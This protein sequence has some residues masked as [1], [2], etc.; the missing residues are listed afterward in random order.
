MRGVRLSWLMAALAIVILGLVVASLLVFPGY[1]VQRS[2]KT[3]GTD[4]LT[5]SE[6]LKAENDARITL[7]QGVAGLL[8]VMGA[9]ATWRQLQINREGQI[10]ERFN[11]AIEHLGQSEGDIVEIC[12]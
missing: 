12:G 10:T 7:L 8:L 1:L 5:A 9:A 2:L 11:K 3:T 4:T 6:R